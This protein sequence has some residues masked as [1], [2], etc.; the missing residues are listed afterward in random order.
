MGPRI[1]STGMYDPECGVSV[2]HHKPTEVGASNER[3]H[4]THAPD[5]EVPCDNPEDSQGRPGAEFS[6]GSEA[7]AVGHRAR[8]RG[9][10]ASCG[11]APSRSDERRGRKGCGSTG[12][13]RWWP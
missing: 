2:T 7:A 4:A 10:A 8:K 6:V 5:P 11:C 12:R 3:L 9:G 13:S 1:P